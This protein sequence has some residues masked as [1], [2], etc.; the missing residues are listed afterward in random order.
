MPKSK[1]RPIFFEVEKNLEVITSATTYSPI[2][3]E[4]NLIRLLCRFGPPEYNYE[5][6]DD[7]FEIDSTLDACYL[8]FN[9]LNLKERLANLRI[10]NLKL[11]KQPFFGNT[12]ISILDVAVSSTI[13][14]LNILKDLPP[15][16]SA[17]LT[18]V[19]KQLNY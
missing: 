10:L 17:W 13:H 4:V 11:K 5:E 9:A 16:L 1:L 14:Q 3:G 8:L 2:L 12:S 18:K 15:A 6:S 7:A 19:K